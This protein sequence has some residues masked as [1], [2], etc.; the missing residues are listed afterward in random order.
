MLGAE[1]AVH[2]DARLYVLPESKCISNL[3]HFE[4]VLVIWHAQRL[5]AVDVPPLFEVPLECAT[6]PVAIVAADLTFELLVET[7]Q[8]VKPVWNWLAI[9]TQ[10]QLEWV[11]DVGILIL[12]LIAST[13][14]IQW[15]VWLALLQLSLQLLI[16]LRGDV[17][18]M[19]V[20]KKRH[21]VNTNSNSSSSSCDNGD[22]FYL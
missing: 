19:G 2:A 11:V 7:V 3:R 16:R 20:S 4:K 17:K 13:S 9:P 1:A 8:L 6:A 22:T 14:T 12:I 15:G 5:H 10:R 18:G 21:G